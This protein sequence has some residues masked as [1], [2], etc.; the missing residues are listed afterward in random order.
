Q[1]VLDRLHVG[2]VVA[3]EHHHQRLGRGEVVAR[4]V[5]PVDRRQRKCRTRAT[6]AGGGGLDSHI[7]W[8]ICGVVPRLKW[9][10]DN[11]KTPPWTAPRSRPRPSAPVRSASTIS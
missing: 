6:D 2:A 5:P 11:R 4:V 8:I 3:D 10:A 1:P 9:G 7:A